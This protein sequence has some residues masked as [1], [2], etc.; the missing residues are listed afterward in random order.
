M[1]NIPF[2]HSLVTKNK[3]LNFKSSSKMEKNWKKG[4]MEM[5]RKFYI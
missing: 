5:N 3:N 2:I 4:P 1:V